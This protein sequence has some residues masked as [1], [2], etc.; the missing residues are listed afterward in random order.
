MTA[1]G[2]TQ[3]ADTTRVLF[4]G[5]SFTYGNMVPDIVKGIAQK[6]GFVMEYTMHAP[7]G[8]TIGDTAQGT[9][10]H[11]EN[12]TVFE[13]IRKGG[14]DY[15]IVQ[16]NQGRF[17]YNYGYF[18]PACRTMEGHKK[19]MDSTLF[20]NPCAKMVWFSGWAFK[21]G[22][23]PYGNTGIELIDRIDANYQF[24]NDSLHQVISPI[25]AAWRRSVLT[26]PSVNLWDADE[27]HASV[28]GSYLTAAV[29]FTTMFREDPRPLNFDNGLPAARAENFR[30]IAFETV[31]DSFSHDNLSSTT[32]ALSYSGGQLT[33]D[34]GY[35]SY[36]WYKNGT[37]INAATG[38]T[39]STAPDG[40]FRVVGKTAAGCERRSWKLC[41]QPTA[42][43]QLQGDAVFTFYPNPV[44]DFITVSGNLSGATSL[45]IYDLQGRVVLQEKLTRT[46]QRVDLRSL[47]PGQYLVRVQ[48]ASG[49][50]QRPLLKL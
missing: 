43:P 44:P 2:A 27:A 15:V 18:H 28:N 48:N 42:V 41:L 40:C 26:Q 22:A 47:A 31:K 49:V 37:K 9:Y 34:A 25:G 45:V 35:V 16:D 5:N 14:W 38:P 11:M 4:I 50:A 10:A 32:L 30:K 21:N 7:P 24:L 29:L 19:L 33:T 23:P 20:H 6:G 8:A 1:W 36:E 13:H 3:A 39:H 12:P 17:I 46:E